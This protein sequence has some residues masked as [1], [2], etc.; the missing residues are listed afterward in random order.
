MIIGDFEYRKTNSLFN[1]QVI[2][3]TMIKFIYM[4]KILSERQQNIQD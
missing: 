3:D 1:E 2:N 4:L